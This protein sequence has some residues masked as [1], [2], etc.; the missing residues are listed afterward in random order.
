[1]PMPVNKSHGA[2]RTSVLSAGRKPQKSYEALVCL[3]MSHFSDDTF[4]PIKIPH[5]AIS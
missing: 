5:V 4:L 3:S 1:M 2:K